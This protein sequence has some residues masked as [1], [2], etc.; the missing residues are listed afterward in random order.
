MS[1][2]IYPFSPTYTVYKEDTRLANA[3]RW[4]FPTSV[5][6]AFTF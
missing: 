6:L 3:P 1:L 5:E 4:S 2:G